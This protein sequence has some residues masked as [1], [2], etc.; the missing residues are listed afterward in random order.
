MSD[1]KRILDGGH[2]CHP[3][4]LEEVRW[5]ITSDLLVR[6]LTIG[7]M[8]QKAQENQIDTYHLF[9]DFKVDFDNPE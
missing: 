7:Q 4:G 8:L 5:T 6:F 2:D 1:D 9:I 3:P